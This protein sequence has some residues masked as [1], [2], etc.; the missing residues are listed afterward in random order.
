ML[1]G[2][3]F[4][5]TLPLRPRSKTATSYTFNVTRDDVQRIIL[6]S[7][8]NVAGVLIIFKNLQHVPALKCY[9]KSRPVTLHRLSWCNIT[10]NLTTTTIV[11]LP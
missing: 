3:S 1:V 5:A 4:E 9:V 10:L 8:S 11:Q 6:N 7:G 2:Q